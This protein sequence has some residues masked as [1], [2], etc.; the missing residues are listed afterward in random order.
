MLPFND[1]FA[2]RGRREETY[3]V[4][5]TAAVANCKHALNILCPEKRTNIAEE[6]E[7]GECARGEETDTDVFFI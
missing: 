4:T 2:A 5:S 3:L 6:G 1:V 7:Q